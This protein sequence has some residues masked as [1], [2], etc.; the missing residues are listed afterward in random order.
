MKEMIKGKYIYKLCDE[1]ENSYY[2]YISTDVECGKLIKA[3]VD[4]YK[5]RY[6]LLDAEDENY[7]EQKNTY[8]LDIKKGLSNIKQLFEDSNDFDHKAEEIVNS[9]YEDCDC[10]GGNT[11]EYIYDILKELGV[12]V[13]YE[14]IRTFY[15]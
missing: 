7:T 15:Y 11:E 1:E 4:F 2:T 5:E 13:H 8:L 3:L 9:L 14:D 10:Y 6:S 12:D